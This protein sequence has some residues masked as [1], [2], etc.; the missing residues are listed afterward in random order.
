M[1][2]KEAAVEFKTKYIPDVARN[3]YGTPLLHSVFDCVEQI[4]SDLLVDWGLLQQEADQL[5]LEVIRRFCDR[6]VYRVAPFFTTNQRRA[7]GLY[8][9]YFFSQVEYC[10]NLIFKR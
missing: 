8:Y 9:E 3:E 7:G 4:S 1:G 2:T 10:H 6:W 5:N